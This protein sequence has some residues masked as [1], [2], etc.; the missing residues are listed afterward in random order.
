M[1]KESHEIIKYPSVQGVSLTDHNSPESFHSHWHN[2][3]EF[4][5]ILK[6]G[7]RYRVADKMYTLDKG[8]ILLIWPRELHEIIHVPHEGSE[9]IQF[10]SELLEN[11]LDLISVSKFLTEYHIIQSKKEPELTKKIIEQFDEI[12]RILSSDD[13]FAETKCKL[14]V[15]NII[16]LAA[17]Y[18]MHEEQEKINALHFS[19]TA[20]SHIH[21]ACSYISEHSS[22]T[23]TQ[24]E[25]ADHVGLSPY[26]FSR[27]FREYMQMSFPSYVSGIRVRSAIRLLSD[28]SLSI[29]DTAFMSGFQSTTAFNKVFREVTG[30]SPRDFRKLHLNSNK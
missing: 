19:Y 15:Y 2:A 1:K 4:T 16:L 28:E 8:D 25:V 13:Q 20:W 26:Y 7:C 27:L 30:C 24:K 11:N 22:D 9:F 18:V 10:S 5:V 21:K 23:I 6:N 3:A 14:C 17:E 29:T 12:R